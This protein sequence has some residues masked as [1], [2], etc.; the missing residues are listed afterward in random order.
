MK[1]FYDPR[2]SP[3]GNRSFSPSAG[4]PAAAVASWLR[5]FPDAEITRFEPLSAAEIAEAHDRRYVDA[6]LSRREPNGFGNK[7]KAVTASLPYTSGSMVAAARHALATRESCVSPTSGFHHAGYK[8]GWGFCTFNGLMIAAALLRR[9]GARRV[10]ILD[11]DRHFGDGTD[12]I[13]YCF[14]AEGFVEHY[15][16]GGE[17]VGQRSQD[18]EEWLGEMPDMVAR[19]FSGCD[20]VLYQAGAD[21]HVDD[22]LGGVLT[23][24]QL[25]R[26]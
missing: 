7:V 15:S 4:K 20:V 16:F 8:Q 18:P 26:R 3:N 9:D 5:L 21:P 25:R 10:G 1:I 22:P 24:E 6:V 2:Q 23:T 12:N 17:L 14:S 11:L 19:R 13:I